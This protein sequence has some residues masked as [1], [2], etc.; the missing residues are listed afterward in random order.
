MI[1]LQADEY[2]HLVCEVD[3]LHKESLEFINEF[4]TE[5]NSILGF[6]DGFQTEE[7]SE[8]IKML[9]EIFQGSLF[10]EIKEIFGVTER[11]LA[12][13]GEN[14]VEADGEGRRRVQWE[15]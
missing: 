2:E 8:T 15:E 7:V 3:V 5:L 11:E 12:L 9:L 10:P 14:A 1:K 13:L 4:I 6:N